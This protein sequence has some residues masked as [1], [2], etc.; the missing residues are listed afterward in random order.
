MSEQMDLQRVSNPCSNAWLV[1]EP[2]LLSPSGSAVLGTSHL[3]VD[4]VGLSGKNQ[5]V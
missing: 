4:L 1:A 3:S 5:Q 2:E